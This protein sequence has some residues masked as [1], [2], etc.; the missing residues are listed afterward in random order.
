MPSFD[1]RCTKNRLAAGLDEGAYNAPL[2]SLAGF[3]EGM[4]QWDDREGK[5]WAKEKGG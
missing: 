2:E 4:G 5:G 1:I 3:V